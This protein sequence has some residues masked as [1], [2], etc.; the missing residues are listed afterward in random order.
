MSH[1]EDIERTGPKRSRWARAVPILVLTLAVAGTYSNTLRNEF[2]LD[3]LYR[4]RDNPEIR[5]VSPVL[6]HFTDPGTISGSRGVSESAL[7]QIGQYRPLLPLTLSLNYAV[8]G[9]DL[10]GYHVVNIAIHLAGCVLI[11]LLVARMLAIARPRGLHDHRH[12]QWAALLVALVYAVHPLS[13]YPVN[14]ILARDLLLM[15]AFLVG[16]LLVYSGGG[17]RR[18]VWRW[19]GTL[20]LLE[21]ALLSKVTAAVAPLLILL[22]EWTIGGMS[23]RSARPWKR[24]APY[25]AVVIGHLATAGLLLDFGDLSRVQPGASW[26]W[27]YALSQADIHLSQYLK[28]FVWPGAIRMA[29]LAIERTSLL[30]PRVLLGVTVI[31][32]S[33]LVAIRIRRAAPV[34]AFGILGYWALMMPESS[35]IPISHLA[36]HYRAFPSSWLLYLTIGLLAARF[37]RPR[38]ATTAAA[39]AVLALTVTSFSMNRIYR[40]ERS[41][42]AHSVEHGGEALAHM[43]YAMSLPDRTDPRVREHLER[44]VEISPNYVLAHINLGLLS[45]D[46]GKTE[47]GL[48]RLRGV[49]RMAPDWPEAHY[50]LSVALDRLSAPDEALAEAEKAAALDPANVQHRDRLA[51][52]RM[53]AG[54]FDGALAAARSVLEQDAEQLD[55]RF[56]EAYALLMLGRTEES[57]RAYSGYLESRPDDVDARFDLAYALVVLGKCGQAVEQ[58]GIV[59]RSNPQHAA[60]RQYQELCED[61]ARGGPAAVDRAL[62]L[63]YQAAF[64]AYREGEY[65]RSLEFLRLVEAIRHDHEET[66]FLLGFDLQML[67]RVDESIEAYE[68]YLS[69]HPDAA[70]VHFNVGYALSGLGRCSE[71][72]EHL[73]RTLEL[74]PDYAEARQI[75]SSCLIQRSARTAPAIRNEEAT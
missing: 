58:L 54:Y 9:L 39:I 60:A 57:A 63:H 42:W 33:L 73:D 19:L 20:S 41:L 16:S 65:R 8:G 25:A 27:T 28:N 17:D 70:Q 34:A 12:A 47:E 13:G 71:A 43:N 40:T 24:A 31:V 48:E 51:M 52:A 53:R 1:S 37:L 6:R 5:R 44:A 64:A 74:R 4:I 30:D 11:F 49:T 55:A 3:D 68:A 29:P 18:G 45:I 59:L 72:L 23:I 75:R 46:E 66:L 10:P 35:V 15:E 26:S 14:Y 22:W 69:S 2:H 62:E 50:W 36:V 7:N 67:G 32:G 56:A 61:E 21:L 38:I